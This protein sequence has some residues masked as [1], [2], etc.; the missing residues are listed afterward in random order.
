MEYYEHP[1]VGRMALLFKRMK[2]ADG[3]APFWH[4]DD[5]R[6]LADE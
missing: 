4:Y 5:A 6:L 2:K 1:K 3:G